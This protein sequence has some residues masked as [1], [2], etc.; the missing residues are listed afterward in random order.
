[1]VV[2]KRHKSTTSSTE[3]FHNTASCGRNKAKGSPFALV[4]F[5]LRLLSD[6]APRLLAGKAVG[7]DEA[8]A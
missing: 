2:A 1:M 5:H 3:L 7:W 8:A 4:F 6:E